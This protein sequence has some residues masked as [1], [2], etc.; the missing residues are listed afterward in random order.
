[1]MFIISLI[2]WKTFNNS[3]VLKKKNG[4][5]FWWI[6]SKEALEEI[7]GWIEKSEVYVYFNQCSGQFY[8]ILKTY[9]EHK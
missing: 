7:L 3:S 1:M 2:Y 8:Y 4:G 9:L 6:L 5:E